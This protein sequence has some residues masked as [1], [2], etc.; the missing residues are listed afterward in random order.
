[1]FFKYP[2]HWNKYSA[3]VIEATWTNTNDNYIEQVS[4]WSVTPLS[5]T[6]SRVSQIKLIKRALARKCLHNHKN[7]RTPSLVR[8]GPIA[9]ADR[10]VQ[11]YLVDW[12]SITFRVRAARVDTLVSVAAPPA[13]WSPPPQGSTK[14]WQRDNFIGNSGRFEF[15]DSLL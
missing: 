10:R 7:K 4:R 8:F 13:W 9:F 5:L 3:Q 2:K 6:L 15:Y 14:T 12:F 1:M 11:G